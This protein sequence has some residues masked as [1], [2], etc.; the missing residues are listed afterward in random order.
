MRPK[1]T[2]LWVWPAITY[3]SG[4][5][6]SK[7]R[8]DSDIKSEQLQREGEITQLFGNTRL[9]LVYNGSYNDN[10][11]LSLWYSRMITSDEDYR[12]FYGVS[13]TEKLAR[14]PDFQFDPMIAAEI[15]ALRPLPS[16]FD[17]AYVRCKASSVSQ[18]IGLTCV[19]GVGHDPETEKIVRG[20]LSLPVV[21]IGDA[22]H[23]LPESFSPNAISSTI[24]DAIELSR[25]II[26]R[27]ADDSVFA[28]IPR[29]FYRSRLALWA[30]LPKRWP[31]KWMTAHGFGAEPFLPMEYWT[32]QSGPVQYPG[33]WEN[34]SSH[35][36]DPDYIDQCKL[37][38]EAIDS[39]IPSYRKREE[40]RWKAIQERRHS[41]RQRALAYRPKPGI[42]QTEIVVRYL[43]SRN[44]EGADT[45]QPRSQK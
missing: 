31:A 27:Y 13:I 42:Q 29:E 24:T 41:A 5:L 14:R 36:H 22:A 16:P 19:M 4:I 37:G 6:I 9:A 3:V 18:K 21:M 2:D 8:Y 43:D 17:K 1:I 25:M 26:N 33:Y 40:D 38:S 39:R 35:S 20:N 10:V 44:R 23:G 12:A 11:K 32:R 15:E 30:L 45:G 28:T 7:Q 34:Q